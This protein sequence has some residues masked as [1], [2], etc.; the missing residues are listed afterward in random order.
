MTDL[1]RLAVLWLLLFAI[2]VMAAVLASVPR[3]GAQTARATWAP[4]PYAV[5][6]APPLPSV[7]P[8]PARTAVPQTVA[9]VTA[10][11]VGTETPTS[12][13]WA[14]PNTPTPEVAL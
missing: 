10:T 5:C 12:I 3:V 8:W 13:Y 9:R 7:T 11:S 6:T 1:R 4:A 14:W 2:V